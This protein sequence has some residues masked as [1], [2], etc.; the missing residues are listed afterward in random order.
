MENFSSEHPS[1]TIFYASG[2]RVFRRFIIRMA[3]TLAF[4]IVVDAVALQLLASLENLLIMTGLLFAGATLYYLTDFGW[5]ITGKGKV[6]ARLSATAILGEV[7]FSRDNFISFD[8]IDYAFTFKKKSQGFLKTSST[9]YGLNDE[10]QMKISDGLLSD[11]DRAAFWS[12]LETHWQDKDKYEQ[13][14]VFRPA[15]DGDLV[16]LIFFL[17]AMAVFGYF[18]WTYSYLDDYLKL[19]I[20]GVPTVVISLPLLKSIL[21]P[22][23]L[24]IYFT[25]V[26]I[27][28]PAKVGKGHILLD[29][30][31]FE[32]TYL[33][34]GTTE[35]SFS[36]N[37]TTD[38]II[39]SKGYE[40]IC[41]HERMF[42]DADR[43]E[44]WDTLEAFRQKKQTTPPACK[45]GAMRVIFLGTA[46]ANAFPEA[47][48]RCANCEAARRLGGPS[49]RKRSSLLINDDLLI[50]LGPDIMAAAQKHNCPLTGVRFCL[51]THP[52]ADHMDLSHLLS[53]SPEY[54]TLGAPLLE[55]Y[56]SAETIAKA[57][58]TFKRDM[59]GFSLLDGDVER[60]LNLRLRSVA[61]L[62]RFAC[63]SYE[64]MAFPANHSPSPG[65][66]LYA[67]TDGR[68]SIFYGADTA[69]LPKE[70]WAAFKRFD[71][72]FDL[73]ILDHTYGPE[74]PGSDHLCAREVSEHVARMRQEG[75]LKS[76]GRAFATHIAHEGNPA[77]PE[78]AAFAAGQGYEVAFDG[79]IVEV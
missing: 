29:Q 62:T 53:R 70:T 59:A 39:Y 8:N 58:E 56:A 21:F 17:L 14:K 27:A 63:G 67:V 55:F 26:S 30:I 42:S 77:H 7:L 51:Q 28:G 48:C 5:L 79:L 40:Q 22:K 66:Y 4:I 71:W 16:L 45:E 35:S 74:Q 13:V 18:L 49:L 6:V 69:V 57:D 41:F 15:K 38:S 34:R 78:L 75:I 46:A 73:V 54:G 1:E 61:P 64:V 36:R 76:G 47:F 37:P 12:L 25:H 65:A 52:H 50:D 60:R 31:D 68:V 72:Q 3:L 44:I 32:K 19:L 23:D 2:A 9:I 43:L 24:N 11:E 20:L 10:R 33:N